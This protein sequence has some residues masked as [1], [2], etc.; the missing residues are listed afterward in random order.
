[1]PAIS[2]VI[3]TLNEAKELPETLRALSHLMA[4]KKSLSWMP[5]AP[6]PH[7]ILRAKL[8]V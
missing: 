3:P 8:A 4:L 2:I 1:M 6:T 7:K 5:A